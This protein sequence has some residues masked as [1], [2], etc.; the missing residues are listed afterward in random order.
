[1]RKGDIMKR[2]IANSLYKQLLIRIVIFLIIPLV[3]T[4]SMIIIT[5]S[6]EGQ[7]S[8]T[9]YRELLVEQARMTRETHIHN[10]HEI[11]NSIRMNNI[12]NGFFLVDYVKENL[13]YY[14]SD[15]ESIFNNLYLNNNYKISIYYVNET[16]PRGMGSFY[17]VSD[18]KNLSDFVNSDIKSMW[19]MPNE[20]TIYQSELTT[21]EKNYTYLE[22]VFINEELLYIIAVSVPMKLMD[23]FLE[24]D[25]DYYDNQIEAREV[26]EFSNC[27]IINMFGELELDGLLPEEVKEYILSDSSKKSI[28]E[29][30]SFANFQQDI[31]Y[32]FPMY[33]LSGQNIYWIFCIMLIMLGFMI[34]IFT[35]IDRIFSSIY[36]CI[37]QFSDSVENGFNT[38]LNVKGND[39]ITEIIA[40]FNV[41]IDRIQELIEVTIKQENMVKETQIKMLQHQINPHF[42]YNTLE[43]FSYKMELYGHEEEANALVSFSNMLRY[44]V[45]NYDKYTSIGNELIQVENYMNIQKLKY[46]DVVF[47][48]NIPD[49][50]LDIKLLKFTLQPIIENCFVHGYRSFPFE[51]RLQVIDEGEYISFEI[52]DNGIGISTEKLMIINKDLEMGIDNNIGIGLSNINNRMKFLSQEEDEYCLKIH[53]E[54]GMWT[55]VTWKI[56]KEL[57]EA[58]EIFSKISELE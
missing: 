58:K 18:L 45:S 33:S 25:V 51:I 3:V 46:S 27:M 40:T 34:Y 52:A 19:I 38:K 53:S 32:C 4:L 44:N 26:F 5:N 2:K 41:Q 8:Y 24:V 14:K 23:S 11:V 37:E 28:V 15:I 42:L 30:I 7:N 29:T 6:V 49:E 31:I 35:F 22:K 1:M 47:V 10:V 17:Y 39:E 55:K 16:I 36:K 54:K 56:K 12:I 48:K 21:F 57:Y 9:V 20:G 43:V 13:R 50:L